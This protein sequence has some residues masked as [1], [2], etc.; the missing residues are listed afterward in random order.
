MSTYAFAVMMR[1][2]M[3]HPITVTTLLLLK[4]SYSSSTV[5]LMAASTSAHTT[6][7]VCALLGGSCTRCDSLGAGGLRTRITDLDD[8]S[9]IRGKMMKGNTTERTT[10]DAT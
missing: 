7:V 2:Q 9:H 10:C 4:S 1:R 6:V 3:R 5:C 8:V